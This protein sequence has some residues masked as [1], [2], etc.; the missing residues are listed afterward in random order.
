MQS[1]EFNN[2][3]FGFTING[4][5]VPQLE[6]LKLQP[7]FSIKTLLDKFPGKIRIQTDEFLSDSIN[8]KYFRPDRFVNTKINSVT[9]TLLP[10]FI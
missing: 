2:V 3:N 4:K 6:N 7:S 10:S 8:S 9:F 1:V 5:D